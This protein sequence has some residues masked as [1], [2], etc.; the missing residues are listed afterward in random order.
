MS[1][2]L[3]ATYLGGDPAVSAGNCDG[4]LVKHDAEFVFK[5]TT[6]QGVTA[7]SHAFSINVD[8]IAA[9]SLGDANQMRSLTRGAVGMFVGGALGG[10]IGMATG[11]RN[12]M[13]ALFGKRAGFDY[14]ALFSCAADEG[15][16][17]M[18]AWQRQRHN[19]GIPALPTIDQLANAEAASTA[20]E[21]LV[22][23]RR[24]VELLEE[25]VQMQRARI[26]SS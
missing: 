18:D 20:D 11:K 25:L 26:V 4:M 5:W 8:E 24:S 6:L 7:Q 2:E 15:R 16:A 1:I 14:T 17:F 21:Q 23:L 10:L 22:L 9:A 19:A 13:L 12:T 3:A